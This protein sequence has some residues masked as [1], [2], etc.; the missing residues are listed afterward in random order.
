MYVCMC[1]CVGMYALVGITAS[2]CKYTCICPE[3]CECTR[4]CENLKVIANYNYV[5]LC[6]DGRSMF[7]PVVVSGLRRGVFLLVY[8]CIHACLCINF[9]R[10]N[11]YERLFDVWIHAYMRACIHISVL[12]TVYVCMYAWTRRYTDLCR[13]ILWTYACML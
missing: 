3:L 5:C 4:I 1:P 8:V 7:A 11:A 13:S 6:L 9:H 2:A 10:L 12:P